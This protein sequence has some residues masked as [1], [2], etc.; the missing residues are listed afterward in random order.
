MCCVVISQINNQ[1][2]GSP[3]SGEGFLPLV[4]PA[5]D[6]PTAV[7]LGDR[8][9]ARPLSPRRIPQAW[10]NARALVAKEPRRAP[11]LDPDRRPASDDFAVALA[12]LDALLPDLA[13]DIASVWYE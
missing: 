6:Q 10:E 2:A 12:G 13:A 7:S 11:G 1:L 5:A 3:A 4:P 9:P 8:T